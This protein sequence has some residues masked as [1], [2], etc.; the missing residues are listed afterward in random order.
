MSSSHGTLVLALLAAFWAG[1]SAVFTGMK[2]LIERRDLVEFGR[3]GEA[4][5]NSASRRRILVQEWAP[6]RGALGLVSAMLC[7]VILSLPSLA[8]PFNR[9]LQI[10]SLVAAA[11]PLLG[12][13]Y[14]LVGGVA[15]YLYLSKRLSSETGGGIT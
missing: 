15:E 7:I 3:T 12:A 1:T 6:I 9:V 5:L 2:L 4:T 10:I 13:I 11:V 14:F 8:E